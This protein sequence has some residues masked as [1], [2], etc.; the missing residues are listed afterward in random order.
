MFPKRKRVFVFPNVDN[1]SVAREEKQMYVSKGHV[2]WSRGTTFSSMEEM[3]SVQRCR[4]AVDRVS[5]ACGTYRSVWCIYIYIYA[6][7]IFNHLLLLLFVFRKRTL[8]LVL[9]VLLV[10]FLKITISVDIPSRQG[11]L[12]SV[13]AWFEGEQK[14]KIIW[15]RQVEEGGPRESRTVSGSY[16]SY[17]VAAAWWLGFIWP[18]W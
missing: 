2:K 10:P 14:R 7:S 8:W 13:I 4:N 5:W 12:V 3:R 6:Y 17:T 9:L 18:W 16:S 15:Q 1:A 11:S